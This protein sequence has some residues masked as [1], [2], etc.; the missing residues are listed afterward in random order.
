MK[1]DI[2]PGQNELTAD[3]RTVLEAFDTMSTRK[4]AGAT[5]TP[6]SPEQAE[7]DDSFE[8]MLLIFVSEVEGDLAHMRNALGHLVQTCGS[9]AGHLVL[10]QRAAHKIH[11]TA[12]TMGCETMAALAQ[13]IETTIERIEV[14][15]V[16]PQPGIH[17]LTRAVRALEVTL[18]SFVEVGQE[19]KVFLTEVEAELAQL[20]TNR[21][22][23]TPYL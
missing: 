5:T 6:Y 11:G 14:G 21:Q 1:E 19:D 22:Q 4:A 13:H 17:F 7:T 3:D 2:S 8:D 23:Q 12:A 9:D 20:D 10:L 16:L 18:K 15:L